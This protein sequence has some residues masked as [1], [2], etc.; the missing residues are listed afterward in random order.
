MRLLLVEDDAMIGEAVLD[1][2]RSEHYAVDW[3]RD[4]GMAD[5]A[6][7]TES[8]D[9]VLLD[10]GLPGLDGCEVARRLR[11]I[12]GLQHVKLL[13]LSGYGGRRDRERTAEAGFDRHLVKPV[14]PGELLSLVD[15][16]AHAPV[17]S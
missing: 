12:P 17:T 2:L 6:L 1:A 14:E 4:G 16:L 3:V 8:Y 11:G 10:L 13:A 5:T 7:R 15:A 9:L